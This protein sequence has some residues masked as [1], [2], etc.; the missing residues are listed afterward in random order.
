M[1][2][3]IRPLQANRLAVLLEL[4]ELRVIHID[5][6]RDVA[7][8]PHIGIAWAL[9]V[10]AGQGIGA[11]EVEGSTARGVRVAGAVAQSLSLLRAC[12]TVSA[13]LTRGDVLLLVSENVACEEVHDAEDDDHDA[14][15]NDNL[16]EG[17]AQRFLTCGLFVQVSEDGDAEDDHENAEGHEARL[18]AEEGPVAGNVASEE[19]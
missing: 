10:I 6:S 15:G 11:V 4:V 17:G 18:R 12:R 16:P 7:C 8:L 14:A 13:N 9:G 5:G 2:R 1:Q 19:R 3:R